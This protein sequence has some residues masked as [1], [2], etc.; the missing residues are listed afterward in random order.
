[1]CASHHCQT[2]DVG[3][4]WL[5]LPSE[6]EPHSEGQS[7][8]R[9]T[10]L[11]G[12]SCEPAHGASGLAPE[13]SQSSHYWK[14]HRRVGFFF[15]SNCRFS[16]WLLNWVFLLSNKIWRLLSLWP[17][18]PLCGCLW[19][20]CNQA[21]PFPDSGKDGSLPRAMPSLCDVDCAWPHRMAFVWLVAFTELI[22]ARGHWL[23]C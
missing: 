9:S 13:S 2:G 4:W 15:R 11:G 3:P 16:L 8:L 19:D 23:R 20:F 17:R 1:M 12:V 22:G 14:R 5:S 21:D 10:P 18:L 7:S 6:L